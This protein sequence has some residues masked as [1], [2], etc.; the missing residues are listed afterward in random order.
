MDRF[1]ARCAAVNEHDK[2]Q[3]QIPRH[4]NDLVALVLL[5]SR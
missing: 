3:D 4:A 2:K 5:R 1:G